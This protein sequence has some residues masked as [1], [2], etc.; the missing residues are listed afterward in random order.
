MCVSVCLCV[1]LFVCVCVCVRACVCV[2]VRVH[3]INCGW[4]AEMNVFSPVI[5]IYLSKSY[6]CIGDESDNQL[7]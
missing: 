7:Q 5:A 2:C 4:L 6:G 3:H 1:C